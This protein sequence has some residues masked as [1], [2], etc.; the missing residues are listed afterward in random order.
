VPAAIGDFLMLN[1]IRESGGTAVTVS[2]DEL[3]NGARE[4][5]RGQGVFACPEGG[6]AWKAIQKL[7]D[8]GWLDPSER[9]VLFNTGRGLKYQHL[10]PPGELERI[11]RADPRAL[12]HFS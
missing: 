7:A 10:F 3:L 5:A 11:D 1:V 8:A 2:D 6:A 9:I 4:L 12:D